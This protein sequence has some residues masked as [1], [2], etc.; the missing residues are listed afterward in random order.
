MEVIA[1]LGMM[2]ALGTIWLKG[3]RPE[4]GTLTAIAGAI[5]VL[6]YGLSRIEYLLEAINELQT[7]LPIKPVYIKLLLKLMGISFLAEFASNICKDAGCTAMSS[8]IELFGKLSMLVTGLPV[9][10]ALFETLNQWM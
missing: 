7:W 6:T 4:F 10:L 9:I 2:T 1:L 8:Q 3:I 5:I